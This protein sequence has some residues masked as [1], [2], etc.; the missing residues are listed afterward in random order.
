MDPVGLR[1]FVCRNLRAGCYSVRAETGPERGR[2]VAHAVAVEVR[3]AVLRVSAAGRARVLRERTKNVH[4]GVLG[5]CVG[6]D[7]D[8]DR[9]DVR[10]RYDPYRW[11]SFVRG[12]DESAVRTASRVVLRPDGVTGD[13]VG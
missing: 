1:V 5:T 11:G 4:A 13:D 12:D 8:P 10:L 3:D 2:V 9:L 7:H 6:V